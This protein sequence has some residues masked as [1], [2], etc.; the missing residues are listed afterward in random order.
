MMGSYR[1]RIAALLAALMVANGA[2]AA[3]GDDRTAPKAPA[4]A[5]VETK[6]RSRVIYVPP[7]RGAPAT[8]TGAGTRGNVSLPRLEVLAP[9]H[10]GLTTRPHPTL[11]WF[12]AG[13]AAV[14]LELTLMRDGAIDPVLEVIVAPQVDAGITEVSLAH[15]DVALEEGVAYQWFVALVPDPGRPE[16]ANAASGAIQ[17]VAETPALASALAGDAPAY[18]ALAQNGIWYDALGDLAS[19]IAAGD[20]SL[21]IER[22]G[23][24]EQV[25]LDSAAAFDRAHAPNP[26]P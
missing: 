17:R 3:D 12:S 24:L 26:S 19:R 13:P 9:D 10:V 22:A 18:A 20:E 4:D 11:S 1:T 14:P 15:W 6:T 25:G 21:R 5:K 16:R 23:L 7:P 2:G 8:R